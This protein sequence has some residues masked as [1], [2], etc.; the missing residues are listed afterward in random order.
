MLRVALLFSVHSVAMAGVATPCTAPPGVVPAVSEALCYKEVAPTN[1]SG[2]SLRLYGASLNATFVS[3]G[4]TGAFPGG[5]QSSIAGVI[6]YFV[7]LRARPPHPKRDRPPPPPPTDGKQRRKPQHCLRAHRALRHPAARECR[8]LLGG[9]YGGQP[10]AV[11]RC[12]SASEPP[13]ARTRAQL[14]LA[15]TATC[16]SFARISL[17]P[18]APST[19][20]PTTMS[21]CRTSSSRGQIGMRASR[22]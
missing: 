15:R 21:F 3:S 12:A 20:P 2:V 18:A 19:P 17:T 7:S 6:S 22:R 10:N 13:R 11:P 5:I 16:L 9:L 1:P 4:A 14:P 8:P